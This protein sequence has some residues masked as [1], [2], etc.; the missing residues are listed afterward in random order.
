M[1]SGNLSDEPIVYRN[2]EARAPP[3]AASPTRFL[4]HDRPHP[5][6][7]D[8]SVVARRAGPE[9]YPLRRARGYA[10][11]PV[12]AAA[13]GAAGPRRRRRAEEHVLPDAR[14]A[15]PS[16]A[17]TSATW[18]TTRRCRAFERGHRPLSSDCSASRPQVVA[19]DLHPD[20]LRD[21]LR[22]ARRARRAARASPSSTTTP[23]WRRAWPSTAARRRRRSSAWRSTAPATGPDGHD[24]GRRVPRGRLRRLR[25]ALRTSAACRCPAATRRSAQPWRDGAEPGCGRPVVEWAADLRAGRR[26]E[27]ASCGL[28]AVAAR[29]RDQRAADLAAWGG[30][31]TRSPSL[32]GVCQRRHLRGAGGLRARGGR[33]DRD[34]GAGLR[35]RA[36][37]ATARSDPTPDRPGGW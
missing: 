2:D 17:S 16:S 25:A 35:L 27:R 19:R 15:T 8:D 23:T 18:S 14:Q 1:T 33:A 7:R 30:S 24:L 11:L 28:L 34:A 26:G 21:A 12:G 37:C 29:R 9:P 20:Y 10:P 3:G 6:A 13:G 4:L 5:R 31:S 32:A 22:A 36:R